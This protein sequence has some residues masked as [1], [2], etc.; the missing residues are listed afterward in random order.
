MW[1][2]WLKEQSKEGAGQDIHMKPMH[3]AKSGAV[4]SAV[5]LWWRRVLELFL[6]VNRVY[7]LLESTMIIVI[8]FINVE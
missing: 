8:K 7:F 4:Q 6:D 1:C 5:S 2:R 3:M